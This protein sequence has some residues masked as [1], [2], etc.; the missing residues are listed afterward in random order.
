MANVVI[1]PAVSIHRIR[2]LCGFRIIW[3]ASELST[4]ADRLDSGLR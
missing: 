1:T 4:E 3:F 2:P